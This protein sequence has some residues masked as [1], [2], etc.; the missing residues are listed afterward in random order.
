MPTVSSD[1][2]DLDAVLGEPRRERLGGLAVVVADGQ[3][4]DLDRREPERKRARVVLDED[5]D[6]A[7]ERPEQRAVDHDRVVLLVV[8]ADVREPEADGIW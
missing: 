2:V 4:P 3:D 8:G 1:D 7:L 5:P 6:E